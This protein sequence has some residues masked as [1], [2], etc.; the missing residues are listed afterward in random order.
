MTPFQL[1]QEHPRLWHVTATDAIPS[2]LERGLLTTSHI[3]ALWE[4]DPA[5]RDAY[6]AE[7]R[8]LP[9][10]LTHPELG[11]I[12]INDNAPLD[13]RKLSAVLDDGLTTSDWLRMLN[14]RV[15]FFTTLAPL[16]R[17]MGSALN[18]EKTKKVLVLNT[19]RLAQ[20]YGE[21]MEIVPI[22]S[23]NTRY[24]PAR[25]GLSTFAPLMPTDYNRWRRRRGMSSPDT[26][27]EVTIRGAVPDIACFID[28][29]RDGA[30]L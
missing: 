6:L 8:R 4:V 9:V 23:G 18:V 30:D 26:I 27:K 19:R 25:R 24:D 13:E 21:A 29:I 20:A 1:A 14:A 15:F 28:D 12:V 22:N 5:Q 11:S 17:L 3:L 2:I 10:T 7:R 16:K